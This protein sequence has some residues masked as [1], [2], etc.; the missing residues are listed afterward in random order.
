MMGSST[1]E[2]ITGSPFT[3]KDFTQSDSLHGQAPQFRKGIREIEVVNEGEVVIHLSEPDGN[4]LHALGEPEGGM[5]VVSQ[6]DNQKRG[7]PTMQ[8]PPY[9]GTAPYQFVERAQGQYIRYERVPYQHWRSQPDFPEF[10]FRWIKEPSTR[11]AGLL[12][13]E[14]HVT[15]LPNDLLRNADLAMAESIVMNA[16]VQRP[17]VCNAAETLLVDSAVDG[18]FLPKFAIGLWACRDSSCSTQWRRVREP[19]GFLVQKNWRVLI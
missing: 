7:A 10:E 1:W 18:K 11:L 12:T 4:F 14:I 2:S 17:G 15:P 9:A 19:M 16:K 6:A 5:E 8:T 3:W 13:G